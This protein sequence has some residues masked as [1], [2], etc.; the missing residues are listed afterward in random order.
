MPTNSPRDWANFSSHQD[1]ASQA[2]RTTPA[3]DVQPVAAEGLAGAVSSTRPAGQ[4]NPAVRDAVADSAPPAS[5]PAR[6]EEQVQTY[7]VPS[8]TTRRIV[9]H[10]V[11]YR[12]PL[13]VLELIEKALD[14]AYDN[15]EKMT[16]EDAVTK[17]IRR[18]YGHLKA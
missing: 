8:R 16:K 9:K 15:N 10:Q 3:P 12:L 14:E 17:A 1:V 2:S 5:S 4:E 11:S 6:R 7:E 18:T 13:D